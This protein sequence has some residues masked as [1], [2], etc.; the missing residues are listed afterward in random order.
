[1]ER[2]GR[3]SRVRRRWED[4]GRNREGGWRDGGREGGKGGVIVACGGEGRGGD[5]GRWE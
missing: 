1:M 5:I 2:G 4:M 3:E